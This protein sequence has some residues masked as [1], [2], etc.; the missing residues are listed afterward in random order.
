MQYP[1]SNMKKNQ[2]KGRL[3]LFTGKVNRVVGKVLDDENM[4]MEGRIRKNAGKVRSRYAVLKE[5][6]DNAG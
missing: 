1:E 6:I 2:A 5:E 3:E 4:D